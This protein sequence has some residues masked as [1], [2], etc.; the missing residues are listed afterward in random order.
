MPVMASVILSVLQSQQGFRPPS[1]RLSRPSTAQRVAIRQSGASGE[2]PH[3]PS[4]SEQ[5]DAA[6][7]QASGLVVR[8]GRKVQS[9][10]P[11]ERVHTMLSGICIV[12]LSMCSNVAEAAVLVKN[13]HMRSPA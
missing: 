2:M 4:V 1:R 5:Q 6:H 10:R 7:Q 12:E 11:S 3:S 8:G 13:H 9:A